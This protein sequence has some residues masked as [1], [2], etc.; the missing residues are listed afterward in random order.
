MDDL[1]GF[2]GWR[3]T[4]ESRVSTLEVSVEVE[5]LARAGMD[6]DVSDL[7]IQYS[8]QKDMLQALSKVQSE[9]TATLRDHTIL[10]QDHTVI[11]QDHTER[12]IRLEEGQVEMK[13]GIR[14]IIDL[15]DPTPKVTPRTVLSSRPGRP[16]ARSEVG[17][18]ARKPVRQD[19]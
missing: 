14:T 4:I 19:G 11:L 13:A 10:L 17:Y 8:K 7:K 18:P 2:A 12:L 5:K 6:D 1:E 15:L 3:D 16:P 9:H